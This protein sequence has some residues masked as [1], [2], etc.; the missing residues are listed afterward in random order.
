MGASDQPGMTK[1]SNPRKAI[2]QLGEA[3]FLSDKV[4]FMMVLAEVQRMGWVS[5]T[6]ARPCEVTTTPFPSVFSKAKLGTRQKAYFQCL[7][8]I[9][10]LFEK[11]LLRFLHTSS[12]AY[13]GLLLRSDQPALVDPNRSAADHEA[14]FAALGPPKAARTIRNPDPDASGDGIVY[15]D[16]EEGIDDSDIEGMH[17]P[18]PRGRRGRKRPRD[19]DSAVGSV[20]GSGPSNDDTD[21]SSPSSG[22]DSEGSDVQSDVVEPG[23]PPLVLPFVFGGLVFSH[24]RAFDKDCITV[25]CPDH[26]VC[27]KWRGRGVRQTAR[28]GEYETI[29]FLMAWQRKGDAPGPDPKHSKANVTAPEVAACF[30]ELRAALLPH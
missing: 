2:P 27:S 3:G 14:A 12:A 5:S 26:A 8:S 17:A 24:A 19:D 25:K 6:D 1:L 11:G 13:Y 7:I 21:S 29:A 20:V 18:K 22:D 30:D 28:F 9:G 15:S 16:H 10:S 4:P 23:L